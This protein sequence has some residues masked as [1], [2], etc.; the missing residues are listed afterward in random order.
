MINKPVI[1]IIGA[2]ERMGSTLAGLFAQASQRMVLVDTAAEKLFSLAS[3]LKDKFPA[4]SIEVQTCAREASWEADIIII[5]STDQSYCTIAERIQAVA[6]G[7]IVISV[8]SIIK[9]PSA[10]ENEISAAEELQKLLPYSKVIKT[11]NAL[12]A[13]DFVSAPVDGSALDIYIAGNDEEAMAA[14]EELVKAV[15]FRPVMAG[16]LTASRRLEQKIS[17][18]VTK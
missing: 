6:I 3:E 1:A 14:V 7:K 13:S 17:A 11:F 16:D 8:S 5:A 10:G 15:G 2:T 12:M 4:A 18:A 9:S